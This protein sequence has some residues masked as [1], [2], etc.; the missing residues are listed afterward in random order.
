MFLFRRYLERAG[1][2]LKGSPDDWVEVSPLVSYAGE[3][4]DLLSGKTLA[5]PLEIRQL[6][7]I[8][9]GVLANGEAQN[10]AI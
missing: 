4:L 2:R 10:G 7:D 3:G 6:S 1:V 5:T 9:N 8:Q